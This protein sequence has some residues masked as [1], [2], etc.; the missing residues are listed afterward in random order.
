VVQG[1]SEYAI[2]KVQENKGLELNGSHHFL[3][4]ADDENLWGENIN[5]TKKNVDA[6][7]DANKEVHVEVSVEETKYMIV[8]PHQTT[9]QNHKKK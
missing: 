2:G 9:G 6:L 5:I 8:S 3:V 7:L 4:H 1:K